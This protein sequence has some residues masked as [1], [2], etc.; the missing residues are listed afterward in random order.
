[1]TRYQLHKLNSC[2]GG[3]MNVIDRL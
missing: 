1:V 3:G 2:A